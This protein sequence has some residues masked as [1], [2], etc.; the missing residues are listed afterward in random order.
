MKDKLA[1]PKIRDSIGSF[2]LAI[3]LKKGK[4]ALVYY[5]ITLFRRLLFVTVPYL[6]PMYPWNQ[7][8]LLIAINFTFSMY[9][10]GLRP[11]VGGNLKF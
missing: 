4:W 11:H 2:Y 1:V 5:P 3:D 7:V 6:V 9:Y 10:I 8:Q